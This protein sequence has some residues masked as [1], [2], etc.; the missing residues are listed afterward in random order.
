MPFSDV[1]AQDRALGFR[2]EDC[3]PCAPRPIDQM[4]SELQKDLLGLSTRSTQI[5]AAKAGHMIP[6]EEPEAVINAVQ[7]ALKTV[8]G[9]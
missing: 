4:W 1:I 5:V 2:E 3:V 6:T 9:Q 8:K 7:T